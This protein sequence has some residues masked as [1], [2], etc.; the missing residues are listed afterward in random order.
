MDPFTWSIVSTVALVAIAVGLYF[1]GRGSQTTGA[2]V[3]VGANNSEADCAAACKQFD[4]R[5]VEL[6]M[7]K[8]AEAAAKSVLDAARTDYYAALSTWGLLTAAA[9]AAALAT[10][11]PANLI[12]GLALSAAA[13]IAL[14]VMLYMLG[15]LNAASDAWTAASVALTAANTAV[16]N[17]RSIVISKCAEGVNA[18][19]LSVPNPCGSG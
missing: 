17:A 1:A 19:C 16:L 14:G 13:T 6:C 15:R 7:A 9:T 10:P 4:D 12:I 5:R 18:P 8:T 3:T 2:T 11:W